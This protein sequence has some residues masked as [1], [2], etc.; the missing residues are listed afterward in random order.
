MLVPI[1]V[2]MDQ[3]TYVP[4]HQVWY[5]WYHWYFCNL[6]FFPFGRN[7]K[8]SGRRQKGNFLFYI[9]SAAYNSSSSKHRC[10]PPLFRGA[11]FLPRIPF[12]SNS[13]RE[14]KTMTRARVQY[15]CSSSSSSSSSS[16]F[17]GLPRL[18][19]KL[20]TIFFFLSARIFGTGKSQRGRDWETR[21]RERPETNTE[22][23]RLSRTFHGFK[24]RRGIE[25][26]N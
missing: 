24:R 15:S 2:R 14:K 7:K 17:L 8:E 6:H 25:N 26:R 23:E 3:T 18:T 21:S 19:M 1:C 13:G 16:S 9:R 22:L 11:F 4:Y 10:G 5:H 20:T 12:H